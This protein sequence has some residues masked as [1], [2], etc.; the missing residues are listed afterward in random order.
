MSIIAALKAI[1]DFD[2]KYDNRVD[3]VISDLK[4]EVDKRTPIDVFK[5]HLEQYVQAPGAYFKISRYLN[6]QDDHGCFN[7]TDINSLE[8]LENDATLLVK[9]NPPIKANSARVKLSLLDYKANR[10]N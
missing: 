1:S 10:V 5:R 3:G 4:L 8:S 2:E 9:L 7:R 6:I